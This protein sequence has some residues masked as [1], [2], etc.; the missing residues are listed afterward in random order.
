MIECCVR[1]GAASEEDPVR[2]EN[3]CYIIAYSFQF[4]CLYWLVKHV[5]HGRACEAESTDGTVMLQC[6]T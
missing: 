6:E 2:S 4:D 3:R 1:C 5:R